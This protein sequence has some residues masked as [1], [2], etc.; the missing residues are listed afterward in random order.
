MQAITHHGAS[1]PIS[2]AP[3]LAQWRSAI[4]QGNHAFDAADYVRAARYY[5]QARAVAEALFGCS[6]NADAGVAA[7]V[8]AHHNLAD[9]CEH[10]HDSAEQALQLCAV[11]E[12]L[13]TAVDDT[14][15]DEPWRQAAWRHSQRTYAELTRFA[16]RHPEHAQARALLAL[17]AAG[18][19]SALRPQ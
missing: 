16:G 13:C 2:N 4:T 15:L 11:H 8:I 18:P 12:I 14:S 19:A 3:G 9:A 17:G 6:D 7:L 1:L 10:L 5:R